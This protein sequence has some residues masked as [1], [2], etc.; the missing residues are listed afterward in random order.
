MVLSTI[1]PRNGI[2]KGSMLEKSIIK[3]CE[4]CEFF[5]YVFEKEYEAR[6]CHIQLFYDIPK[7]KGDIKKQ[8]IRICEANIPD[9]DTAQKKVCVLVK[10]C[11]ND[12]IECYCIRDDRDPARPSPARNHGIR[13]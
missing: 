12:W 8:F 10:I 13:L 7:N 3:Y 6:H 4:K 5:S 9:W 2:G 1:R 11:Y